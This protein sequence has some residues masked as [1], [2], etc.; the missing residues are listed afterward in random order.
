MSYVKSNY[1]GQPLIITLAITFC[2]ISSAN[3][4]TIYSE[5]NDGDLSD[6]NLA[7]PV[8][9]LAGLGSNIVEGSTTNPHSALLLSDTKK[10]ALHHCGMI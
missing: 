3:A 4:A 5:A 8:I 6:N 2:F 10:T 9:P 7:P 1:M